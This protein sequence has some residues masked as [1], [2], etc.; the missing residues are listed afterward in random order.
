MSSPE[1]KDNIGIRK[2]ILVK[3]IG[4]VVSCALFGVTMIIQVL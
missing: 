3:I 2:E 1:S 4:L